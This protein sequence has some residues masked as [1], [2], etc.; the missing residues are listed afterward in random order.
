MLNGCQGLYVLQD[1]LEMA[2]ALKNTEFDKGSYSKKL[3]NKTKHLFYQIYERH[4][5]NSEELLNISSGFR[6]GFKD[7]FC[8]LNYKLL[9][10]AF[11]WLTMM[12]PLPVLPFLLIFQLHGKNPTHEHFVQISPPSS[13]FFL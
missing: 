9:S 5:K 12:F 2:P 11:L 3:I 13:Y 10:H 7:C 4:S 6:D 1:K 8:F